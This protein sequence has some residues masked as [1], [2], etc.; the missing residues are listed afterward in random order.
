[1]K[2]TSK[3][4]VISLLS[5]SSLY[6]YAN[7]DDLSG[8]KIVS[9]PSHSRSVKLNAEHATKCAEIGGIDVTDASAFMVGRRVD[10]FYVC[11]ITDKAKYK[12]TVKVNT[13]QQTTHVDTRPLDATYDSFKI[14][15]VTA[16]SGGYYWPNLSTY[17]TASF[18]VNSNQTEY[19]HLSASVYDACSMSGDV[20][21]P[22]YSD[23]GEYYMRLSC[24][25]HCTKG[26][27]TSSAKA[28]YGKSCQSPSQSATDKVS[29]LPDF[30]PEKNLGGQ[31]QVPACNLPSSFVAD[32]INILTGNN[33]HKEVDIKGYGAYPLSFY[34][35]YNSFD[36]LWRFNYSANIQRTSTVYN[37]R[38]NDG[39]LTTFTSV[40]G[41]T[42]VSSPTE[43][44]VLTRLDDGYRY[45][46]P[47]NEV[48]DFNAAGRLIRITNSNGL[49]HT[50]KYPSSNE[51]V[52]SDSFGNSLDIKEDQEFQ[53]LSVKTSDGLTVSYQYDAKNRL[54]KVTNDGT[55]R[56]YHYED[57]KYQF[58]LT[59]I[60][61]ERGIRYVTWTYDT[62]G[63]ATSSVE[64]NGKNKVTISYDSSTQSTLTNPLGRKYVYIYKQIDGVARITG[65][66]ANVSS[67]CP[68]VKNYYYYNDNNGLL[69]SNHRDYYGKKITTQYGYNTKGQEIT[70]TIGAGTGNALSIKTTWDDLIPNKPKTVTY[71]DKV[72][73]YSYDGKGNVINVNVKPTN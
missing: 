52:V 35:E 40:D 25:V 28:C 45:T 57:E 14:N 43:F 44:G 71:P 51:L 73:T 72:I 54:V 9:V 65:I 3:I 59:G 60:T 1:M 26:D 64:V 63:R 2:F 30:N 47:F 12:Q 55:S 6:V 10:D 56:S 46:S 67:L 5:L 15:S 37:L 33:Y 23:G 53:P 62:Q 34:R 22:P 42:F 58:A 39:R 69:D 8:S 29:A 24:T 38:M 4:V 13:N 68:E 50:I 7:D 48:Y 17:S 18:S 31:F 21:F 11:K 66:T 16:P 36:G 61:N 19:G 41:K 32:P 70:R 20:E 49:A 27:K